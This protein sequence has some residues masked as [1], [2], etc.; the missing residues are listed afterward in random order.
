M[1]FLQLP[2]FIVSGASGVGKSTISYNLLG[3]TK[4]VVILDSDILW[5]EEF[6]KPENNYRNYFEM[7]LRVSK[8]ISQSGKSVVLFGAGLGVPENIEPCIERRY[9]SKIFYL[10]LYCSDD[11]LEKRLKERP[12]W[13]RSNNEKFIEDHKKYNNWLKEYGNR[14]EPEMEIIDTTN[15]TINETSMEVLNWIN[16]K[17][18]N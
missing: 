5:R 6:N 12:Q 9:F 10:G 13:R 7:W 16:R 11:L 8:N 2:L 14:H 17:I 15:K 3:K 18:L 1:N 4:D